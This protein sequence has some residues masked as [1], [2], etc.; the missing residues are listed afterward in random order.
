[1]L[2][3]TLLVVYMVSTFITLMWLACPFYGNLARFM[4]NYQVEI[5]HGLNPNPTSFVPT[6]TQSPLEFLAPGNKKCVLIIA[7][8]QDELGKAAK[9]TD[10]ETEARALLGELFEIYYDN[11]SN[12][13]FASFLF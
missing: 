2:T 3:L 9:E 13:S 8:N 4:A 5:P 12:Q 6:Y 1:M 11:R 7:I 10:Q